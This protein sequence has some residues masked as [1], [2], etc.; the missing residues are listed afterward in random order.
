MFVTKGTKSNRLSQTTLN[1]YKA[2]AHSWESSGL[3]QAVYCKN[4]GLNYHT[5]SYVRSKFLQSNELNFNNKPTQ[6]FIA[7]QPKQSIPRSIAE[8]NLV[9]R[10]DEKITLRLSG[11]S[12]LELPVGLA[13]SQYVSLFNAL[14]I[15]S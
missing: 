2:H 14:G 8:K 3:R 10:S 1:H 11:G 13:Q 15:N 9:V 4:H 5:F 7:V 6:A 12:V